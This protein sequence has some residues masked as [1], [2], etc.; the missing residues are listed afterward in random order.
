MS[1]N[2][3]RFRRNKYGAKKTHCSHGHKHDSKKEAVRCDQLHDL[4][5]AGQISDLVIQPQ[6]FFIIDGKQV[7]HENGR[8]VGYRPDFS[9]SQDG[10]EVVEDVK[11]ASK[12]AVSKDYPLRKAIFKALHPSI[13]FR[14]FNG[15]SEKD[16]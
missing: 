7:K 5:A 12:F 9:Y 15:A 10:A 8:R 3:H 6:F 11:P 14:E 2:A 13:T 1:A 4:W 16:K